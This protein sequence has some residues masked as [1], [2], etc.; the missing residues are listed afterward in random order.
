MYSKFKAKNTKIIEKHCFRKKGIVNCSGVLWK[1]YMTASDFK[2]TR[3]RTPFKYFDKNFLG[4]EAH[5]LSNAVCIF[6]YILV[7]F[8]RWKTSN[9]YIKTLHHRHFLLL[10]TLQN[11]F[12]VFQTSERFIDRYSGKEVFWEKRVWCLNSKMPDICT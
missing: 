10:V 2:F 7:N 11:V 3:K 4:L 6:G 5:V 9:K 1:V 8:L 12:S